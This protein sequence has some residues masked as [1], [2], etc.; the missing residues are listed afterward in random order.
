MHCHVWHVILQSKFNG[1]YKYPVPIISDIYVHQNNGILSDFQFVYYRHTFR[2]QSLMEILNEKKII[3][4]IWFLFRSYTSFFS[5]LQ[6]DVWKNNR[7]L[8]GNS[9]LMLTNFV[10]IKCVEE[11]KWWAIY[12]YQ[13][14]YRMRFILVLDITV[15][16]FGYVTGTDL[17][18]YREVLRA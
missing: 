1:V 6:C 13:L 14:E 8:R 7:K 10:K 12:S 16:L 4:N 18:S 15:R 11:E 5:F 9:K 17:I 3:H 2:K